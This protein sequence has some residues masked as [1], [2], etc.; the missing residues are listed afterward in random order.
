MYVLL[1]LPSL[2]SVVLMAG[3][4]SASLYN[5]L[6]RGSVNDATSKSS[7]VLG[8]CI[9]HWGLPGQEPRFNQPCQISAFSFFMWPKLGELAWGRKW[10]PP[11]WASVNSSRG[12]NTLWIDFGTYISCQV[13]RRDRAYQSPDN[14][15]DMALNGQHSGKRPSFGS[16]FVGHSVLRVCSGDSDPLC[17]SHCCLLLPHVGEVPH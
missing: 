11:K 15:V 6:N 7:W 13:G 8:H 12:F 3:T 1:I 10:S 14:T 5:I 16:H 2:S 17:H 4:L 9:Y